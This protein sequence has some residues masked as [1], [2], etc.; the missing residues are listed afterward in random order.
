MM[1]DRVTGRHVLIYMLMFFGVIIGVNLT[2]AFFAT[3]SWTGLVVKNSY[4]ASQDFNNMRARADEQKA[5]GWQHT[6]SYSDGA[7]SFSLKDKNGHVVPLASVEVMVGRPAAEAEDRTIALTK[8]VGGTYTAAED[9][10]VG[11]WS[12]EIKAIARDGKEWRVKYRKTV[13]AS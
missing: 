4:V 7:F 13:K 1:P 8:M 5:L 3:G 6:F 11:Q 12:M 9:L 10:S 2:M